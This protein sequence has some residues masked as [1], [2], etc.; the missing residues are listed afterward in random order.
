MFKI[1]LIFTINLKTQL[2]GWVES[3][4]K[5]SSVQNEFETWTLNFS[6]LETYFP[7][8]LLWI[9]GIP[10]LL[11][12]IFNTIVCSS[13]RNT[14]PALYRHM[15]KRYSLVWYKQVA[16]MKTYKKRGYILWHQCLIYRYLSFAALTVRFIT[17][18]FIGDYDPDLG[19]FWEKVIGQGRLVK[20]S[21]I[22]LIYSVI[23]PYGT[24]KSYIPVFLFGADMWNTWNL[25][26][27]WTKF[28]CI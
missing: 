8:S 20:F 5:V 21:N 11:R 10:K 22:Y 13:R 12:S 6:K 17:R 19:K 1:K 26:F 16:V 15:V 7:N 4:F 9:L 14:N 27:F 3:T 2:K 23:K 25:F 24:C 18:R 28:L